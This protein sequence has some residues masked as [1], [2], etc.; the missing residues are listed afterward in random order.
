MRYDY[1][2]DLEARFRERPFGASPAGAA[3]YERPYASGHEPPYGAGYERSRT[4]DYEPWGY[5]AQFRRERLARRARRQARY[6]YADY[7][8]GGSGRVHTRRR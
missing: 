5:D 2:L 8:L 3:G 1:D 4:A 7:G 6:R